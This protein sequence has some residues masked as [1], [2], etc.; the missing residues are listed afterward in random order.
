MVHVCVIS[1][2][3][4][5]RWIYYIELMC[6]PFN[7]PY[8]NTYSND[9]ANPWL[10]SSQAKIYSNQTKTDVEN[11]TTIWLKLYLFVIVW[12]VSLC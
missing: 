4:L 7:K 1:V 10:V 8:T 11:Y 9:D 6:I 3:E 12:C 5:N 2:Q